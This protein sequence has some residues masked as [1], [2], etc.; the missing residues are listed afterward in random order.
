MNYDKIDKLKM[1]NIGKRRYK[2]MSKKL[3]VYY[4]W[5]NGNTKRIAEKLAKEI[6]ADIRHID[7]VKSLDVDI[8]DYA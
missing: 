7:T 4:S 1:H 5:S 2:T 8:K 6:D 3:V